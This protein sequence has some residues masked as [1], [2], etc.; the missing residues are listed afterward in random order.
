M[1]T[2]T[3]ERRGFCFITYTDEEPV[4]KLLESR[5]HQIGSGKVN[6]LNYI[7][8]GNL[9]EKK[10]GFVFELRTSARILFVFSAKSKLHSPKRC[11][12]SNSNNRRAGE[13]ERLVDEVER[14]GV[15]EV[16]LRFGGY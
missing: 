9:F 3:N 6:P 14:G 8:C 7:V 1:D 2:K 4:K 5:Y 11:T 15:D 10:A 12:G 16:R 13:V